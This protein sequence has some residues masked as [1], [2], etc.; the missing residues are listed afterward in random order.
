MEYNSLHDSIDDTLLKLD[1]EYVGL[2]AQQE[3]LN[4]LFERWTKSGKGESCI[5][6]GPTGSGRTMAV[7]RAINTYIPDAKQCNY[8]CVA[9]MGSDATIHDLIKGKSNEKRIIIIEDADELA[10]RSRQTLLFTILDSTRSLPW[11]VILM[12]NRQDFVT[13]LEK[14]VRSRLSS[15][16]FI[17]KGAQTAEEYYK[18]FMQFLTCGNHKD[19]E[20]FAKNMLKQ[21]D[22]YRC[23]I[24]YFFQLTTSYGQ[25]KNFVAVFL[26]ILAGT[27]D[28]EKDFKEA[29]DIALGSVM[30]HKNPLTHLIQDLSLRA[31]CV[32]LCIHRR[33]RVSPNANISYRKVL[34]DYKHLC[35]TAD[36]RMTVPNDEIIYKEID[37]LI[38]LGL[39]DASLKHNNISFRRVSLHI[40]LEALNNTLKELTIPSNIREWSSRLAEN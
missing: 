2:E 37:R 29:W 33:L 21:S 4:I 34:T 15:I 16:K 11:L 3:G 39:C 24:S 23:D 30:P 7:G 26:S 22:S 5:V 35:K 31:L 38:H 40:D 8:I 6:T 25:L 27:E 20:K 13:V 1:D 9:Q 17:C 32:L 12:T 18:A 19:W 14:R 36:G 28:L 10:A